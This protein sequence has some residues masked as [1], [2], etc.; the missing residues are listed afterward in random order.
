MSPLD[1]GHGQEQHG[2]WFAA[3]RRA[4]VKSVAFLAAIARWILFPVSLLLVPWIILILGFCSTFYPR[5]IALVAL[6][7]HV[8]ILFDLYEHGYLALEQGMDGAVLAFT[9]FTYLEAFGFTFAFIFSLLPH[10]PRATKGT[11]TPAEHAKKTT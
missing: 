3:E 8:F 11:D 2:T 10:K 9:I 4:M 5:I 7:V 6:L 1:D